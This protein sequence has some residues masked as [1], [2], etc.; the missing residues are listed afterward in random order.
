M[1]L[2]KKLKSAVWRGSTTGGYFNKDNWQQF[3]RT[4]LVKLS[5]E[6]PSVVNARFH[7]V[8]QT[9]GDPRVVEAVLQEHSY[10]GG[11]LSYEEQGKR[12][13]GFIV[14]DGNSNSDRVA[15]QLGTG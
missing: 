6:N 12:Y 2:H 14:V 3:D 11:A 1:G 7:K 9:D 15:I 8:L 4:K 10:M 13:A 5:L